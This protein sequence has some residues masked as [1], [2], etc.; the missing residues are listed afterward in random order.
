MSLSQ[1]E[2]TVQFHYNIANRLVSTVLPNGVRSSHTYSESGDVAGIA[3]GRDSEPVLGS[4]GYGY[5][6]V[7]R[8]VS[9]TGSHTSSVLPESDPLVRQYDDNQRQ[10]SGDAVAIEHDANGNITAGGARHYI[11]NTRN[12][13]VCITEGGAEIAD[14]IYDVTGH[15][16]SRTE[17]GTT[18]EYLYNGSMWCKKNVAQSPIPFFQAWGLTSVLL[19]MNDRGQ[20]TYCL[21]DHLGS[22]RALT[23]ANGQAV[24]R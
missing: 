23:D 1:T 9:Q 19:A 4:L 15:R 8:L 10:L 21:I 18:V 13:L 2:E 17:N 3:W 12:E 6:S 14:F 16:I 5:D 11:W 24:N 20:R 22:T 7:D